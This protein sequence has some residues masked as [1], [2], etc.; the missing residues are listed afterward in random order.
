MS[1]FYLGFISLYSFLL[2]TMKRKWI[3]EEQFF[4][5]PQK[6]ELKIAVLIPYRNESVH[7]PGLLPNVL[8]V[9]HST[10]EVILINDHSDD[11]SPNI[12]REF[13]D[14]H[15]LKLW[16]MMDN[17][18]NGKKSAL[19]T[20]I[21]ST[22]AEIIL[23]TDADCRLTDNWLP[24]I[25]KH[26]TRNSVQMV[27]GSVMTVTEK[28]FFSSFQQIEWASILLVMRYAFSLNKPL[29]VSGANLA[30]RRS[31]FGAVRG[32]EGNESHLS[33][34]DEFLLKKIVK[35]YGPEALVFTKQREGLVWTFPFIGARGFLNQ[36]IR[37]ASKWRH[38][39]S[40]YHAGIAF[41]GLLLPVVH[42]SSFMLLFG[43]L[44][45]IGVFLAFWSA[46]IMVERK[47]LGRI[48]SEYGIGQTSW[49]YLKTSCI[50]PLYSVWIGIFGIR[51][52]FIWKGRKNDF[53]L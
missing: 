31:A 12:V 50:H 52:K 21:N 48:L 18:G 6:N 43:R 20:A 17:G 30:Y 35:N 28:G 53:H 47:V 15:H 27:A 37:W 33:G 38:H 42:L 19:T 5:Y 49:A 2:L 32:Y 34:D 22:D 24:G 8:A 39:G 23:T 45:D 11:G 51:G 1:V 3:I 7:L 46:K 25:C 14:A 4:P 44:S 16:R 40:F 10:T 41:G 13:I 29:M 36:R 9:I 26:F